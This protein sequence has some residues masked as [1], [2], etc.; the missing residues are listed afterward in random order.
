MKRITLGLAIVMSVVGL[1]I[2]GI[3]AVQ[4]ANAQQVFVASVDKALKISGQMANGKVPYNPAKAA[5][6]MESIKKAVVKFEADGM[7]GA[8][9]NVADCAKSLKTGS[10][11]GVV[12]AKAG[13]GAFKAVYG[14][15]VKSFKG[16]K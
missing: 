14:T 6:A 11:K 16:C 3:S 8:P 4:A 1:T 2:S 10:S 7:S 5:K 9:K 15:L 12:A 13:Q